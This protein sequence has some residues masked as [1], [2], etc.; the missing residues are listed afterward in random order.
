MVYVCVR[1]KFSD[2]GHFKSVSSVAHRRVKKRCSSF[3]IHGCK[4]CVLS[5]V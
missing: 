1:D 2:H 4:N 3:R 5:A